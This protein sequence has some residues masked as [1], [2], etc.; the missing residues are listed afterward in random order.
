MARY[1]NVFILVDRS[2]KDECRGPDQYC[3][4]KCVNTEGSFRCECRKGYALADTTNCYG[5]Y[6]R[7]VT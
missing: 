5:Q 2:D 1:I 7:N 3:A 4:H 6:D